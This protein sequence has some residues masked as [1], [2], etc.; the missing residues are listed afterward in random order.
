[1]KIKEPSLAAAYCVQRLVKQ[2]HV[3]ACLNLI[4][5]ALTRINVRNLANR[6]DVTTTFLHPIEQSSRRRRRGVITPVFSAKELIG[7][8]TQKGSRD[9]APDVPLIDQ[10]PGDLADSVETIQSK[11]GLV[12]RKLKNTVG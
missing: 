1:M 6:N 10:F 7:F 4:R 3:T 11:M 8:L 5:H 9:D 2:R 12:S